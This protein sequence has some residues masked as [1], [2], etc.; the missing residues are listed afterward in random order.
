M[1][2][3]FKLLT[4]FVSRIFLNAGCDHR[5]SK[6]IARHL[7]DANLSGH[8]SHGVIRIMQYIDY[9]RE[10]TVHPGQHIEIVRE[11]NTAVVV[12][13]KL[14]FGQ[15]L[16]EETMEIV[17]RKAKAFGMAMGSI[18]NSSHTGRLGDWAEQLA[19]EDLISLHFLNTT[20]M[21]MMA[22][23]FGG[24]D[25]R[26]SLCAFAACVPVA[27]RPPLL[28]DFTTTVMAE[29]KLRVA[30]NKG[31]TLPPGTIVDRNGQPSTDPND[32]Y[33]G[34]AL[35]PIAAHKGHGLNMIVDILAG[36]V[37]GG[38]C[39]AP[40]EEIL[41]NTMTCIAID[42]SPLVNRDAYFDEIK[43]YC[44]WVTGSPPSKP[45]NEVLTPGALEHRTR[46][47]RKR[48][49]IPVDTTTW[50]QILEIANSF[51]VSYEGSH[52]PSN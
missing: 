19:R 51:G 27:G 47:E 33:D 35:L 21:G 17:A 30:R 10:G 5:E 34:G 15:V 48:N 39:T 31:E 28:L 12:D 50:N 14:G 46:I 36:A 11:T 45:G 1:L 16:G 38:G 44:D 37:S 22:V 52:N 8:D 24:T 26:L 43:R 9:L 20:G 49:G 4:E 2:T 3:D 6:C 29:G 25:R 41:R 32:F 42:P 13:G 40:D 23:P 18:G 7:V